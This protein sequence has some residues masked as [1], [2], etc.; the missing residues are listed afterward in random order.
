[1]DAHP[2]PGWLQSLLDQLS[3]L[4]AQIPGSAIVGRYIRSS[5]QNDPVRSVIELFL[6]VFAIRYL[7]APSYSTTKK[8]FAKLSDEVR[9]AEDGDQGENRKS[10]DGRIGDRRAR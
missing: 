9:M 2:L 1:M 3:Q 10:A 8:G 7:L 5:Y 4:L 6:V